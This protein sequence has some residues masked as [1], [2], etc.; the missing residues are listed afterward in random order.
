MSQRR[1]LVVLGLSALLFACTATGEAQRPIVTAALGKVV[2]GL[3]TEIGQRQATE[4]LRGLPVVVR[5]GANSGESVIAEMLRTRLTER[6][7]PVE[8]A[9]PAKCF[10]IT[11]TGFVMEATSQATAGQILPVNAGAIAGLEGPPLIPKE[12]L[13]AGHSKRMSKALSSARLPPGSLR[14]APRAWSK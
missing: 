11:L 14:R 10:E 2:E 8:V 6:S 5:G 4:A 3:A 1:N 7:V 12:S 9:C 13:S